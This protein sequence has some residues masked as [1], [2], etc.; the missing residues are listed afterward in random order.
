MEKIS[1]I[2]FTA[3]IILSAIN[4]LLNLCGYRF[5]EYD[6]VKDVIGIFWHNFL[7]ST[8]GYIV[9]LFLMTINHFVVVKLIKNNRHNLIRLVDDFCVQ[10][11]DL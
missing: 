8:S 6:N 2:L 7:S 9:A 1:K 5:F 11:N 4:L 3:A 10:E